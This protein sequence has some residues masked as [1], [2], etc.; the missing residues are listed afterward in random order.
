MAYIDS[1]N[2][3]QPVLFLHGT[4]CDASDWAAVIEGL[5]PHLRC[6]ALDFRG[7]GQSSVPTHPFIL[8]DLAG[9]VLHLIDHLRLQKL[10]IVGHSLGGMVAMKVAQHSSSVAGLVLLEGWTSLSSAGSAFD[11]GR[12]YGSLPQT[13]ITQIQRKSEETRSRFKSEVWD[14]EP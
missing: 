5:P 9:D 8:A 1:D 6:I 11:S 10:V 2:S 13:K 14:S 3:G 12:I 7:H 4:G